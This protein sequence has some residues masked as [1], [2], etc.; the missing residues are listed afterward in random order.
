[1]AK[2]RGTIETDNINVHI[3]KA[4]FFSWLLFISQMY[5]LISVDIDE[6][7]L[8]KTFISLESKRYNYKNNIVDDNLWFGY[9]VSLNDVSP[10]FALFNERASSRVMITSSLLIRDWCISLFYILEGG[11]PI[12]LDR[13]RLSESEFILNSIFDSEM[14]LKSAV[15]NMADQGGLL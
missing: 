11:N 5:L 9:K 3:T 8:A 2:I 14:E 6:D 15:E 12:S 7:A 1:M 4:S 10:I 13:K